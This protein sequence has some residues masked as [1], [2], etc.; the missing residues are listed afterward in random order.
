MTLDDGKGMTIEPHETARP[1]ASDRVGR[2]S[3]TMAFWAMFS[4]M[5]WLYI[6]VAS[7]AAV[8][9]VNTLVGMAL[10]IATYGIINSVL[11]R[12]AIKTGQTISLF[13]RG[14][15]GP[16]GS[17]LA[18]LLFAVTAIYYAVFEGSIIAVALQEY[19]GGNLKLWYL[20]VVIYAIPLVAGG[21]RNW[22]DKLN[23][24]LLPL[25]VVG[26]VAIVIGATVKQGYPTGW[27]GHT[28][29]AGPLPGWMTSYL[30]YMGVWVMM[31]YT[32]DFAR[33]GKPEDAKFHGTVTFGWV[34]YALTFGL[35]GLIGIYLVSAWDLDSTETGVVTAVIN[36]LGLLGVIV[37]VISQTRINTANYYS[38]SAN[39]QDL[40]AMMSG[41]ATPRFLW[42]VV[43]GIV[44]YLF[45]LT[46]V[47]TYLLRAL[48]WQ[49][50]FVTSWVAI[51]LAS[52]YFARRVAAAGS[53]SPTTSRGLTALGWP[54]LAWV[55][56]SGI[57]IAMTEQTAS[58]AM[59]LLA[60]IITVVLAIILYLPATRR[61]R[62]TSATPR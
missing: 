13:S 48:A 11:A 34:F 50:V 20:V 47:L 15:F 1:P 62:S 12:H 52:L 59:A 45:M 49:G 46:D 9:T 44:A 22:L 5:F 21:V 56:S 18:A 57:G 60:P 55:V 6:A 24:V 28:V 2:W 41:K 40:W 16:V 51:A 58:P 54:V 8:G 17:G 23:G 53:T 32:F 27:L 39:L 19:F 3:V 31:M 37:I 36:S 33:L 42:V 7:N 30:I 25:Y 35:N 10:T 14:I 26:L 29:A 43:S 38:A 4:A 61:Q